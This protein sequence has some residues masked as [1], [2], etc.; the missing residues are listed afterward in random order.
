MHPS[1]GFFFPLL[2][3]RID[4][5]FQMSMRSHTWHRALHVFALTHLGLDLIAVD[6]EP[7]SSSKAHTNTY[8]LQTK[9]QRTNVDSDS[10]H[11]DF[12][13]FKEC[14][15]SLFCP[16]GDP[17]G[18]DDCFITVPLRPYTVYGVISLYCIIFIVFIK[19]YV[20]NISSFWVWTV[21]VKSTYL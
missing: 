3:H 13:T 8:K 11:A 18:P 17:E 2:L 7:Y 5:W 6:G 21:N 15:I 1:K 4:K 19:H 9:H 20:Y 14:A 10:K 12:V 16:C